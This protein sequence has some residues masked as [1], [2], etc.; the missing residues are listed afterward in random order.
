MDDRAKKLLRILRIG[1]ETSM[2]GAGISLR[3]ALAWCEYTSSRSSFG[4]S[5][6]LP[7]VLAHEE[8]IEEWIAFSEGK[9]TCG[10]WYLERNG[11]MGPMDMSQ[12]PLRFAS[13][14]EAVANYVVRELDFWVSVRDPD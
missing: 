12:T 8:V 11:E 1:Y 4:P 10:G 2:R 9:R 6:L 7:L 3:E 14:A 13:L 5:D